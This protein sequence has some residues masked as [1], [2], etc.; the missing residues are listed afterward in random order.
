[1]KVKVKRTF[2]DKNTRKRCPAGS[3]IEVTP[4][5]AKEI[6]GFIIETGDSK[7]KGAAK[8]KQEGK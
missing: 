7:E 6:G 4:E 8:E 5:R 2:I 3:V 1:M